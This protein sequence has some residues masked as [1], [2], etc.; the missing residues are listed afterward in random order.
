MSRFAGNRPYDRQGVRFSEHSAVRPHGTD[1]SFERP[2]R[3][4]AAVKDGMMHAKPPTYRRMDM[5]SFLRKMPIEHCRN[6]TSRAAGKALLCI[7]RSSLCKL[8]FI[9]IMARSV[10]VTHY[11]VVMH[12]VNW[13]P[14]Q[15]KNLMLE[16]CAK[17]HWFSL[18]R[19]SFCSFILPKG[20]M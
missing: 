19:V 5:D 10:W 7:F 9:L 13:L 8:E 18:S 1:Y 20:F 11:V 15:V 4:L 6:S 12:W 14:W 2:R 17:C 16:A 3:M